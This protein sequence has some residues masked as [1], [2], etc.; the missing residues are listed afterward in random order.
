MVRA[1]LQN[2]DPGTRGYGA[3]G[4]ETSWD[5]RQSGAWEPR[6]VQERAGRWE[7]LAAS[8]LEETG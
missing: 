6:P 5:S 4:A 2:S 3:Q 7:P 1:A 8:G